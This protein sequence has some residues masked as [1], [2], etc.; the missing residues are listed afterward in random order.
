M[1][2][3]LAALPLGAQTYSWDNSGNGLLKGTY[4]FRQVV[5]VVGGSDGSL[6]EAAALYGTI[7]FDGNG[8]Y[9]TS[10]QIYDINGNGVTQQN[11]NVTGTYSIA[12]SGYGFLDSP[13]VTGDFVDGLVANGIFIGSSTDNGSGYND[14]FIAAPLGSPQPSMS[15][16]NGS[17]SLLSLDM[18]FTASPTEAR[19]ILVN[20]TADGNGHL[21]SVTASGYI[22]IGGTTPVRQSLGSLKYVASNGAFNLQFG[23]KFSATNVDTN[24]ILDNHYIYMSPDG[25]FIFGGSPNGWDMMVGVKNGSAAPKFSGLYYQAGMDEDVS[26]LANGFG[27]TDNYFG[28]VKSLGNG[29]ILGHQR[30][31]STALFTADS[32][33][34]YDS[35]YADTFT[36]NADGSGD[37]PLQHYYFANG[38]AIRI[39]IGKPP[40]NGAPPLLGISVALQA[41]AMTAPSS[42]P[43]IDPTSISNSASSALFTTSITV[44]ELVTI[45]GS[46][47]AAD[48]KQDATF[49]TTLDGVQV[50]VNGVYAPILSV[51]ECGPYPC[52]TF[53]VPYET[54]GIIAQIQL[55]NKSVASN[56]VTAY[57]ATLPTGGGTAPGVFTFPAGGLGYA[58][59]QHTSDFSLITPQNPAH[60]GEVI[61][62]YL[63]GIGPV[64]PAV[65]DGAPGPVPVASADSAVEVFID[66]TQATT[67][68]VGL[69][70]QVI[71][72][73]QINVTVPTGLSAGDH[74]FEV[75][76]PDS[77]TAEALISISGSA[78]ARPAAEHP[79]RVRSKNAPVP[80]K[81]SL[82]LRDH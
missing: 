64:T 73:A 16:L 69:T 59:A 56:I 7:N 68:F 15:S 23:S 77:D 67:S 41:P 36:V 46:N 3:A 62:V 80:T 55:F 47:L 71:G 5:W 34:V 14:L 51:N 72:L 33:N 17:Y 22:G 29:T 82:K 4:Y 63:T 2:L 19:D 57:V 78:A 75:A 38:G 65:S 28:S 13:L 74:V 6:G 21:N 52:V 40:G 18:P 61:A 1:L 45:Y 76:G 25:N 60:P 37:D 12:A 39:G 26:T 32:T 35:T 24:L 31:L 58:A 43:Y 79:H 30:I 70:P 81:R 49:P 11:Y 53:M 50:Q 9:S 8:N 48:S 66:G 54:S 27:N 44:G 20:F 10:A 42:A